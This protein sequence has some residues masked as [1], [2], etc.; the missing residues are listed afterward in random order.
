MRL[1]G[2]WF[3]LEEKK[4]LLTLLTSKCALFSEKSALFPQKCAVFFKK[5]A[6]FP[7]KCASFSEKTLKCSHP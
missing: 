7:K 5:S 6:L 3:G 4:G 1:L 2:R